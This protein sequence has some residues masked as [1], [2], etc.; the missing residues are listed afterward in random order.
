M[1]MLKGE[2]Q[3]KIL[4]RK[5]FLSP[6]M[7]WTAQQVKLKILVAYILTSHSAEEII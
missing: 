6:E 1:K 2:N 5:Y 4:P 7:G 3:A